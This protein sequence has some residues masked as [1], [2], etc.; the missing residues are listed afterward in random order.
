MEKV[1]SMAASVSA[2]QMQRGQSCAGAA[3]VNVVTKQWLPASGLME[4]RVSRR[5]S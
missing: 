3:D 4:A 1:V 2:L 5:R